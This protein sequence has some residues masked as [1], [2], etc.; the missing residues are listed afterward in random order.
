MDEN[1]LIQ[2]YYDSPDV[3][4]NRN[5]R[6]FKEW[7]KSDIARFVYVLYNPLNNLYKIG[8]TDNFIERLRNLINGSG[9]DM[10]III[11]LELG[12]IDERSSFIEEK[13][14]KYYKNKRIRGEWFS[15][16]EKD[17]EDIKELFWKIEGV[18]ICEDEFIITENEDTIIY[19]AI[20]EINEDE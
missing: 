17:I 4:Y 14:H 7:M 15:L 13:L 1:K 9:C 10:D 3:R 11:V 6:T 19:E 2:F 18:N 12:Y 8:I 5:K 20:K 16:N